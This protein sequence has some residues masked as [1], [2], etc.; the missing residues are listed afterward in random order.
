MAADPKRCFV[1]LWP[2]ASAA[3][4]LTSLASALGR[5]YPHARR[6][7]RENLHLTLAF[8]G[9]LAD[10]PAQ[11][12]AQRLRTVAVAPFQWTVDRIGSF[13]G[14]RVCWAGGATPPE[15]QAL[16]AAVQVLLDDEHVPFDRRPFVPHVTL[17][18]HLP[19]T[20]ALARPIAPPILWQAGPPVLL[21][22]DAGRYRQIVPAP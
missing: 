8:I 22:S 4:Q 9:N 18:R 2:D 11:R 7:A 13:P 3:E 20:A 15:L 19:R 14:P 10:A 17:L 6:T 1:G 12:V 21:Q 5:E 16:V